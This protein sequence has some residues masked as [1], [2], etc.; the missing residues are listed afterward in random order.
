MA[1]SRRRCPGF[2]RRC[3]MWTPGRRSRRFWSRPR[4]T[5]HSRRYDSK[6]RRFYRSC[7]NWSLAR[8]SLDQSPAT[9]RRVQCS[10]S[11][12][13]E[14]D[15]GQRA[16]RRTDKATPIGMLRRP[17]PARFSRGRQVRLRCRHSCCLLTHIPV[18]SRPTSCLVTPILCCA[19]ADRVSLCRVSITP[20]RMM[21]PRSPSARRVRK[22]TTLLSLLSTCE[23]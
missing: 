17:L 22:R 11:T 10:E 5:L 1:S 23:S 14:D 16:V 9:R 7:S 12:R 20:N 4:S 21:C 13:A 2:H 15:H 3:H 19:L 18:T 8:R 6:V